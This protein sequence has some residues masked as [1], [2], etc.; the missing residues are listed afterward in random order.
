[1]LDENSHSK[2]NLRSAQRK[3]TGNFGIR[4]EKRYGQWSAWGKLL[5]WDLVALNE[6]SM[7]AGGVSAHGWSIPEGL[8]SNHDHEE[9]Q[10]HHQYSFQKRETL[11][12]K[13]MNSNIKTMGIQKPIRS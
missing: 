4:D 13:D 7:P 5:A 8:C 9:V 3:T 11:V 2:W 6:H 1:M 10:Y 12:E